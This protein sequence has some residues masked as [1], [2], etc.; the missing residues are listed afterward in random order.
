MSNAI[1]RE[2]LLQ[3]LRPGE[4]LSVREIWERQKDTTGRSLTSVK[5]ACLSLKNRGALNA[6]GT[7]AEK[8]GQRSTLYELTGKDGAVPDRFEGS[9]LAQVLA[10]VQPGEWVTVAIMR[11]RMPQ[12]KRGFI[13]HA[14]FDLAKRGRLSR[15]GK[16]GGLVRYCIP[17]S[18]PVDNEAPTPVLAWKN[19]LFAILTPPLPK[20]R[21]LDTRRVL[22]LTGR[23]DDDERVAA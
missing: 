15:E 12:M 5:Q 8:W 20:F 4:R 11:D 3:H 10:K 6:A 1:P 23:D 14:M 13:G 16:R 22:N 18:I 7:R 17:G 21:I 19:P 9:Q 2:E